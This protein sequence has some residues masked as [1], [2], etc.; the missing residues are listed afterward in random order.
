M[1]I[2]HPPGIAVPQGRRTTDATDLIN[3]A[4]GE[5][6]IGNEWFMSR[7][8]LQLSDENRAMRRE[9]ELLTKR[10]DALEKAGAR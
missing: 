9:I 3:R 2:H 1:S 5:K 8:I 4:F 10:L 7:A 6:R